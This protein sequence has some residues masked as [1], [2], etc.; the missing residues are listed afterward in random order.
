MHLY[1]TGK[2]LQEIGVVCGYDMTAEAAVTKLMWLLGEGLSGEA[3]AAK[4]E[5]SL[6]GEL[7]K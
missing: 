5:Q 4:M 2:Q 6:R 1:E 7:S 3:L